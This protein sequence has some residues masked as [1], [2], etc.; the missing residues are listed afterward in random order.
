[1]TKV[2]E[3]NTEYDLLIVTVDQLSDPSFRLLHRFI[4]GKQSQDNAVLTAIMV[5]CVGY[6]K[7]F[8]LIHLYLEGFERCDSYGTQSEVP[9]Q[10]ALLLHPRRKEGY[11]RRLGAME[12]ILPVHPSVRKSNVSE[13][14]HCYRNNVQARTASQPLHGVL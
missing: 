7:C 9:L 2:A 3:I 10:Y 6:L 11:W 1:M 14:R 13:Y 12:G 4:E 8:S 5:S